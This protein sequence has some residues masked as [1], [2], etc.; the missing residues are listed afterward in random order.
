METHLYQRLPPLP[1]LSTKSTP[2]RLLGPTAAL[3]LLVC[4]NSVAETVITI[5]S[6]RSEDQ[7]IRD[8]KILPIFEAQYPEIDVQSTPT[9]PTEYNAA[10]NARL[11]GGT[12]GDIIVCRP[13]DVAL[14]LH[15]EGHLA[16]MKDL[17]GLEE[18][19]T[20]VAR[21]A[22]STDDG[23]ANLCVPMASVIHGFM[24]N[25]DAFAELGIEIPTTLDDLYAVLD[26]IKAD[27]SFIPMAMGTKD[28]W[29]AATMGDTHVGPVFWNGE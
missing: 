13:F 2:R 28:Q 20:D 5:E 10:L 1:Q 26:A 25:K 11:A 24:C 4:G 18:N 16:D 22:W 29:E 8:E 3:A 7:A 12:A 14:A 17:P 6:W 27:G 9:T 19:F 23:R 21:A 15:E